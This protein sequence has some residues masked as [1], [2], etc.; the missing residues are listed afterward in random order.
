MPY[1]SDAYWPD[2]ANQK[3]REETRGKL[4]EEASRMSLASSRFHSVDRPDLYSQRRQRPLLD[5]PLP[6]GDHLEA[7]SDQEGRGALLGQAP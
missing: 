4:W 7:A 1:A 6:E 5:H 2:E 3:L